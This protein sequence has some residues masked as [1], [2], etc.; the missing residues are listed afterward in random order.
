MRLVLMQTPTPKARHR[1]F[2]RGDKVITFDP[3]S[4]DKMGAKF[5]LASQMRQNRI[6]MLPEG[7]THMTLMNYTPLPESW[8]EKKKKA[9]DGQFCCTKPDV[10]NYIKFYGDVL[11]GIAYA[12][13][14]LISQVWSEKL[15]SFTP[16]VEI[17]I[18][19]LGDK[20]INEHAFTVK[21]EIK[22]EDLDYMIKKANKLGKQGRHLSRVFAEE[23]AEGKHI[24]FEV[25]SMK[26]RYAQAQ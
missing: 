26:E 15:Y 18:E 11:N 17:L 16:R 22:L 23:D 20:M 13:D 19:P 5:Q 2:L 25:E 10:D 6:S 7:P 9:F 14:R 4:G 21:G 3:Q 12:D 1:H 24:Y 8:S